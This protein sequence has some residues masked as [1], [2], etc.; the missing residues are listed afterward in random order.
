MWYLDLKKGLLGLM[1]NIVFSQSIFHGYGLGLSN[2][3]NHA[4]SLGI[5]GGHL[6]PVF[7]Q[8]VSLENPSTWQN[9]KFAYLNGYVINKKLSYNSGPVNNGVYLGG[10]QWV[11]PIQ[12]KYALGFSLNPV[13]SQNIFLSADSTLLHFEGDSIY[14]KKEVRTGGG[15]SAL[16]AAFSVPLSPS[17]QAGIKGEYLFGSSRDDN[18]LQVDGI[19]FRK[20]TLKSYTGV[21]FHGTLNGTVIR[22]D[23]YS[24]QFFGSIGG[25]IKPINMNVYSFIP[26][27]DSNDNYFHDISDF[28]DSVIIDTSAVR[29]VYSPKYY[30][31]GF[32]LNMKNGW[33][34]LGEGKW[35]TDEAQSGSD[36]SLFS[37][38]VGHQN[39]FNIGVV[40]YPNQRPRDWANKLYYRGG[41]FKT[42]YTLYSSKK[43]INES[44]LA[45]GLG[46][47]FGVTDNQIDISYRT[48]K[49]SLD[50]ENSE[51]IQEVSIGLSLGDLWFLKRRTR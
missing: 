45:I 30:G 13:S 37:D 14:Y 36:Y 27:E 21:L 3:G 16:S 31:G 24:L 2:N 15:I 9:L 42:K 18:M 22:K 7:R 4:S 50:N 33:H 6:V 25:T 17:L 35:W 40:K 8:S 49:R 32:D 47:K 41:I 26:F 23:S 48:G 39:Q 1:V 34:I 10:V 12:N 19:D 20:I 51:T 29:Y 11:V 44:G 38:H 28:P 43:T 46:I 5:G